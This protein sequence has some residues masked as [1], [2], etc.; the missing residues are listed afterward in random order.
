M[1]DGGNIGATR[2]SSGTT[3]IE[4]GIV[5]IA[6]LLMNR[7]TEEALMQ[8]ATGAKAAKTAAKKDVIAQCEEKIYRNEQGKV[9]FPAQNLFSALS[10]AGRSVRLDGKKQVSTAESSK[11]AAIMTINE[12]SFLLVDGADNS[13]EAKWAS[14]MMKGTN[15]NGGT[16]VAIC[17][18]MFTS[19]AFRMSITANLKDYAESIVRELFDRAGNEIGIGDFRPQKKGTYGRFRVESW[20]IA[21]SQLGASSRDK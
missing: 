14:S 4:I 10:E 5:G 15:P 20:T 17:R 16:A 19:W 11:L 13:Q 12:P 9:C 8:L 18:P 2:T 3:I 1:A 6:P 7:M 21:S